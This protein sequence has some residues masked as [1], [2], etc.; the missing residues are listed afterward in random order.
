[1]DDAGLAGAPLSTP[2]NI[3]LAAATAVPVAET[4]AVEVPT[5]PE[6]AAGGELPVEPAAAPEAPAA[7]EEPAAVAEVPAAEPSAIE[8]APDAEA[9]PADAEPAPLPTYDAW[10]LPEGV[11]L[12]D[13]ALTGFNEIIGKRGL[14]QEAGQELIEFGTRFVQQERERIGQEQHDVFNA[15][16]ADWRKSFETEAGNQR[17][18]ILQDAKSAIVSAIPDET[19][20]AEFWNVLNFTGAGDHPAVIKVFAAIGKSARERGAPPTNLTTP[21]STNPAERRYG[22]TK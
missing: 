16:R 21:I 15:T 1:M 22:R 8:A 11:S 6:P 5:S 2:D 18:T 20:R 9:A 4:P 7:V 19:Q 10:E 3:E 12:P 14:D 17:N 13:E